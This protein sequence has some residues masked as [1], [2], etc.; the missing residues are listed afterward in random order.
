MTHFTLYLTVTSKFLYILL[1]F[2]RHYITLYIP[3]QKADLTHKLRLIESI[4]LYRAK[5]GFRILEFLI[6]SLS[7][8]QRVS[9]F[10]SNLTGAKLSVICDRF[11]NLVTRLFIISLCLDYDYLFNISDN[12]NIKTMFNKLKLALQYWLLENFVFFLVLLRMHRITHRKKRALN[13]PPLFYVHKNFQIQNSFRTDL[14]FIFSLIEESASLLA[15]LENIGVPWSN[16]AIILRVHI[17]NG[18]FRTAQKRSD[19]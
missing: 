17:C 16:E 6:F 4:W 19:I 12:V 14:R 8:C 10:K 18:S 3:Q 15:W 5:T 11:Q 2:L 7:L 1:A 9:I 13:N